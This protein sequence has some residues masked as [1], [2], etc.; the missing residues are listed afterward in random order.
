METRLDLAGA[1]PHR[2]VTGPQQLRQRPEVV[3]AE[4]QPA[5]PVPG[6][7]RLAYIHIENDPMQPP[8]R[9]MRLADAVQLP[10]PCDRQ[11]SGLKYKSLPLH[12]KTQGTGFKIGELDSFV[13]MPFEAPCLR[14]GSIPKPHG[15]LNAAG[16]G[17]PAAFQGRRRGASALDLHVAAL[18][19]RDEGAAGISTEYLSR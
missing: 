2:F 3:A 4:H 17:K 19:R 13:T 7:V 10:R 6:L 16:R 9:D 12:R 18:R 8:R 14:D 1:G 11:V 5:R 15:F